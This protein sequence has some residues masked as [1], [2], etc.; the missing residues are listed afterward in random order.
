[1][2]RIR[3]WMN[4]CCSE[5]SWGNRCRLHHED[6]AYAGAMDMTLKAYSMVSFSFES[7]N[8]YSN[9]FSLICYSLYYRPKPGGP[10]RPPGGNPGGAPPNGGGPPKPVGGPPGGKAAVTMLVVRFS[11]MRLLLTRSAGRSSAS[12]SSWWAK[13][14]EASRRP[15]SARSSSARSR[16][17]KANGETTSGRSSNTRTRSQSCSGALSANWS[18]KTRSRV[19]RRWTI[20]R[21]RYDLCAADDGQANGA[22]FFGL[23]DLLR[24]AW[25]GL[26]LSSRAA[27]FFCV[28]ENEV[29][30]LE[31]V[32]K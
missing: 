1:M 13:S 20:N 2:Q 14:R 10:P 29:H 3:W 22:S 11:V 4:I 26:A 15:E 19:S 5:F 9:W 23:G 21:N 31:V 25:C 28:G 8:P 16:S 27:E 17:S 6:I 24:C 18:S 32:Q 7:P 12:K 30:V